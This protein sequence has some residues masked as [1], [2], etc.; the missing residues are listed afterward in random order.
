MSLGLFF[1]IFIFWLMVYLFA[2][3]LTTMAVGEWIRVV[4]VGIAVSLAFAVFYPEVRGIR[5]GD[6]VSV[7]VNNSLPFF[8][9]LG[10]ALSEPRK[11][12]QLRIRLENGDEA[13]GIVESYEGVLSLPR[14]R[15]LYEEKPL[16]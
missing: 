8:G 3:G 11:N 5:S 1:K 9:R 4:A 12:D 10:R 15:L 16:E 13:T 2:F 14:V 7:I 6:R